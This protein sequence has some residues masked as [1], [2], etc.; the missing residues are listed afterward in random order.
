MSGACSGFKLLNL[1]LTR[2]LAGYN[3][4]GFSVMGHVTQFYS[5]IAEAYRLERERE[6]FQSL[7]IAP[8]SAVSCS[9]LKSAKE[10][11]LPVQARSL[12]C[13]AQAA[14]YRCAFYTKAFF[15]MGH[16]LDTIGAFDEA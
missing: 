14:Q 4:Y 2:T 13:M 10:S 9:L 1:G 8:R 3:T 5:P 12:V 7:V 16:L 6:V 15:D 11:G